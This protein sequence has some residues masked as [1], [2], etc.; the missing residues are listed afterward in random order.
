M[1]HQAEGQPS[2]ATRKDHQGLGGFLPACLM[3][4]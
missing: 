1:P 3:M 2:Q 4:G